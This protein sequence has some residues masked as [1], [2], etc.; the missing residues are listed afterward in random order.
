MRIIFE[1]SGG[2]M[3]SRSRLDINLDELPLDQAETL[4]RILDEANFF[5][6]PEN[7]PT[8]PIPD[9]FQYTLTVETGQLK[10]TILTTDTAA[11]KE[12][13]PLLQELSRRMRLQRKP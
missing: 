9:G 13:Q 2:I 5:A 1:R 11:P 4:R 10:H 3:G 12:L 6:Q 8:H 7:P